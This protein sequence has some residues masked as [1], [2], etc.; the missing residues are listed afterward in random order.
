M[1]TPWGPLAQLDVRDKSV[2][3][4]ILQHDKHQLAEGLIVESLVDQIYGQMPASMPQARLLD[5]ETAVVK[6]RECWHAFVWIRRRTEG[7]GRFL[8]ALEQGFRVWIVETDTPLTT[9]LAYERK[10]GRPV[11]PPCPLDQIMP[12]LSGRSPAPP[13]IARSVRDE[14]RQLASFWGYLQEHYGASLGDRVVM[15][16]LFMNFAIQPW[17]RSVWNLDRVLVDDDR[18][19]LLE[20]KHKYPMPR[21]PLTFGLNS[22]ELEMIERLGASGVK[23]FHTILVKPRW[24]KDAG[25]SY[26]INNFDQRNRALFIGAELDETVVRRMKAGG[27]KRSAA[28]TTFSGSGSLPYLSIPAAAF[29]KIGSFA[30]PAE[31][32]AG[33][34]VGALDGHQLPRVSDDE[35]RMLRTT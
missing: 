16:R 12:R 26:L 33:A 35:L 18:I 5:I 13:S 7:L 34:L 28:H 11:A 32:L 15:P 19:W 4:Q 14:H 23:C 3:L 31:E 1:Q 22:G 27:E 20:I 17:F 10:N 8:Q 21:L 9:F 6:T 30:M 29:M 2:C 25:A 24:D